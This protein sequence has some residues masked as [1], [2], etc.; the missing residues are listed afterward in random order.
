[1]TAKEIGSRSNYIDPEDIEEEK[2][3]PLSEDDLK[4]KESSNDSLSRE[5]ILDRGKIAKMKV[6]ILRK[7]SPKNSVSYTIWADSGEEPPLLAVKKSKEITFLPS[8]N[9]SYA[10]ATTEYELVLPYSVQ[11]LNKLIWFYKK[12]G[13]ATNIKLGE[14]NLSQD[15]DNY[16]GI[17]IT[18]SNPWGIMKN[19]LRIEPLKVAAISVKG[20]TTKNEARKNLVAG[21]WNYLKSSKFRYEDINHLN[22]YT[23]NLTGYMNDKK[24]DC[25]DSAIFFHL[26]CGTLGVKEHVKYI[27]PKVEGTSFTTNPIMSFNDPRYPP[28]TFQTIPGVN[29][30]M[31]G[32]RGGKI[33][34]STFKFQNP[35]EF[36]AGQDAM[37][38]EKYILHLTSDLKPNQFK[39]VPI[40][41][42]IVE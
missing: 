41:I 11:K 25:R 33:F 16:G 12:Q 8:G 29:L 34:D 15:V 30:H 14:T 6:T 21:V 28:D 22:A 18:L 31:I 40:D 9:S 35:P 5:N 24:G 23:F 19:K 32:E 10:E 7:P 20:T 3:E 1:L 36:V 27:S 39:L 42:N 2:S 38:K 37:T 13:E 26:C 17:Y 4:T